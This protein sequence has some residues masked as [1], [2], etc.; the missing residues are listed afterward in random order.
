MISSP[1]LYSAQQHSDLCDRQS[2][3]N[4]AL[5]DHPFLTAIPAFFVAIKY[6]PLAFS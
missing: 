5:G 3:A 1:I 2:L 4:A 6:A